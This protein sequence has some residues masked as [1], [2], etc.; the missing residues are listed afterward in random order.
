MPL[1]VLRWQLVG[2]LLAI[3]ADTVDIVIFQ[4]TDFPSLGYH[5]TDKLLDMY[6]MSLYATSS[7]RWAPDI[8][9]ASLALFLFRLIGV[10]IFEVSSRRAVLVVFPNVFE[11]FFLFNAARFRFAPNYKM[12][13]VRWA[14]WSTV[15]V[16][17]KLL[18][19]Y[20]LHWARWLDQWNAGDILRSILRRVV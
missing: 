16:A 10:V 14:G 13:T 2:G 11:F 6:A 9:N 5:Q 3:V 8:R 19:E 17:A 18:Q 20:T 12:S 7:L 15:L 4:L 1:L